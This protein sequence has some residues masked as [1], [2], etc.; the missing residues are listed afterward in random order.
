MRLKWLGTGYGCH[1]ADIAAL[2]IDDDFPLT[3]FS[4]V[5]ARVERIWIWTSEIRA[6]SFSVIYCRPLGA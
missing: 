1:A 3:R 6:T 4:G 5:D 2:G